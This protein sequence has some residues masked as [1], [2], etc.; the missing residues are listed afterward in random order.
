MQLSEKSVQLTRTVAELTRRC[1]QCHAIESQQHVEAV[2][3]LGTALLCDMVYELIEA[4]KA[5]PRLQ[6]LFV[7]QLGLQRSEI[8]LVQSQLTSCVH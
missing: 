3:R 1:A 7:D 4:C 5:H 2:P 6:E 8:A